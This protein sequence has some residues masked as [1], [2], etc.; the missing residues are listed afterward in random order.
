MRIKEGVRVHGLRGEMV[1]AL[2]IADQLYWE[3]DE[4][5]VVT[6]AMEGEHMRGSL[7]YVGLAADL[8]LPETNSHSL[9]GELAA[10][11][12]SDYD[13]VLEPEHIHVEFQPKVRY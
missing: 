5:L 11:L 7:H 13:V 9:R 10:R 12:G 4:E 1:I 6:S 2:V 3:K 8:R